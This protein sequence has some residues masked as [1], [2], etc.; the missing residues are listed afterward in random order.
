M[1]SWSDAPT[2][3]QDFFPTSL[4]STIY[5]SILAPPSDSEATH[6]RLSVSSV[7]Q[8]TWAGPRGGDG[9]SLNKNFKLNFFLETLFLVKNL[10]CSEN[11]AITYHSLPGWSR[12][13][14]L[15]RSCGVCRCKDRSQ[16]FQRAWSWCWRSSSWL[17]WWSEQN[18]LGVN[19]WYQV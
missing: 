9:L 8:L 12:Q 19:I 4:L 6:C 13:R 14:C 2:C 18:Y 16:D 5:S 7:F 10:K 15:R 11:E 17:L 1:L 3:F